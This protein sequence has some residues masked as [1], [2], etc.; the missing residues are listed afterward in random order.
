R[1]RKSRSGASPGA[2]PR[3]PNPRSEDSGD[4]RANAATK[5]EGLGNADH[6]LSPRL[7]R[8]QLHD[9]ATHGV[10]SSIQHAR[11][12]GHVRLHWIVRRLT[13]ADES[14]AKC[15]ENART[16]IVLARSRSTWRIFFRK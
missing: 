1:P 13:Q 11:A 14:T 4:L 2:A 16:C 10:E 6:V 7:A 12:L 8:Q 3:Q 9:Y 15:F 5:A